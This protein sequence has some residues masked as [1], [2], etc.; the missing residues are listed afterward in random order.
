M[1]KRE[2][3]S[4]LERGL[5]GLPQSDID[6]R[7]TFYGEMIDDMIEDGM[8]EAEAVESIGD[9][10]KIIS[11]AI[12]EVPLGRIVH[13]RVKPKRRLE[14]LEIAL[15]V[16]G[17]PIWLS[18]L[19]V[20][21]SV[22][23]SIYA[24]IWSLVLSLF[25]VAISFAAVAVGIAIFGILHAISGDAAL[26]VI[27]IAVGMIFAGLSIFTFIIG[28]AATKGG[29]ILTRKIIFGIKNCFMKREDAK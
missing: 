4:R 6:E 20:G 2:F 26:G 27:F 25:A 29:F 7:L 10:D 17:S 18:L 5:N 15:I 8:S 24:V 11:Q 9:I 14:A 19:V 1:T 12:S 13:E 3:L 22:L 28:K 16:I 21:I 23:L